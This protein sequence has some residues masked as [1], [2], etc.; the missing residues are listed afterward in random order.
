MKVLNLY[1]GLGGNRRLWDNC[2]VTAVEYN[3]D[4]ANIYQDL[5]PADTVIVDDAHEYLL[6]HFKDFDFIWSSPPCQTHSGFRQHFQVGC[7]GAA[8]LYPDMRLYQEIIFLQA[9]ARSYWVV[10]NVKPY[11]EPLI[12][13]SV[14]L[15]R[16]YFWSNFMIPQ[17]DFERTNLRNEQ[18]PGLQKIHHIDLS[19]Y[20]IPNKRQILRNCVDSEVGKH[21]L[22]CIK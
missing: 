5:Y 7:R 17:R 2:D 15:Q 1:A 21:I 12:E 18:I 8:P 11:Y 14:V 4:I 3:Q 13:Q 20:K 6:Q 9:N 22:S 19:G 10:E 16:H